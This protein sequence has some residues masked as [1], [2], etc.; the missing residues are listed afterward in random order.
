MTSPTT[1]PMISNDARMDRTVDPSELVL[2]VN[3]AMRARHRP[4]MIL[5]VWAWEAIWA[6]GM[7]WPIARLV[8]QTYGDHPDGDGVLFR[9]GSLELADFLVNVRSAAPALAGHLAVL[10]PAG[11]ALGLVPLAALLAS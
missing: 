5:L 7:V 4:R 10:L 9:A 6:F 11:I 3:D 8:A 2:L 1:S